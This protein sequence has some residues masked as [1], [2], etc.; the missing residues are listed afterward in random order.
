MRLMTILHDAR[1]TIR[2]LTGQPGFTAVA[3]ATVALGLG[4][5]SAVVAV[6]YGIL[7][8]PLPFAA[9]ER[10]VAISARYHEDRD[11]GGVTPNEFAEWTSRHRTADLSGYQV[12]ERSLRGAGPS[13]VITAAVVTGDF[14]E[15]LGVPAVVGVAPTLPAGGPRAVVSARL[16]RS[17]DGGSG[18]SVLSEAITV[19]DD[20]YE[21]VGVMPEAFAF[22][23]AEVDVWVGQPAIMAD[24]GEG[25]LD[26]IGRLRPGSTLDQVREDSTRVV[27][28]I[29]SEEWHA[30]VTPLE[31]ALLD[32][33]RPAVLTALAGAALVLIVACASASTLLL[34]RSIARERE[35]AV[36]LALGAGAGRMIR[37]AVVEGLLIAGAGL[38]A[39]LF[40]AWA[41]LQLFTS[42]ATG[43]LPRVNEIGLDVPTVAASIGLAL[44]VGL[45]CGT[46]SA[47]GAMRRDDAEL[48]RGTIRNATPITPRL[49]AALVAAQLALSIVLMTGAGLL[50]RSVSELLA[51]DGGF[52]VA[53]V[54]TA[55]LMLDDSRF[56]DDASATDFVTRLLERVR[57]LPTVE[58]AGLGSLLPPIDA[59][60]T[61][62]LRLRSDTRDD[63][64]TMS[65]GTVTAGFFEAL[66]TSLVGGRRFGE[67]DERA[68][69]GDTIVSELAARFMFPDEDPVGRRP[70]FAVPMF[71][72][73]RDS[74]TIG[75]VADMKFAGLESAPAAAIYVP[76]QLRPTGLSHLVVRASGDPG[77]LVSTVRNLIM[78]LNPNL[79]VPEVRTLDAHIADSIAGDGVSS[80]CR[81]P[82]SPPWR[83]WWPWWGS[84]APSDGRSL[85]GDRSCR[86]GPRSVPRRRG[87]SA[88]CCEPVWRSRP[89]D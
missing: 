7:W 32:H 4:L 50:A 57:A 40:L 60:I 24:Q 82:Q 1:L 26:L 87:W 27:R 72:I 44:A 2:S 65:Y 69:V 15:M 88:W 36:R 43:V 25:R 18:S 23:R 42:R 81:R 35:F 55:R 28:E 56:I 63:T 30:I 53:Q 48:L 34:G 9:P 61:I 85:S 51:E 14:F 41:G 79:P 3:V 49:R 8:R 83:S 67:Q 75:V 21:I 46:A 52:D 89:W 19:G 33:T 71:G 76:W 84:S 17:V 68:E 66:G 70:N 74:S 86:F 64:L 10:L 11:S 77:A 59:P 39:G 37:G 29:N 12:R 54:L 45:V 13:R 80:W 20:R 47:A 62:N 73:E 78:A 58:A 31:D 6:A 16:A 38:V 5:N 22:P